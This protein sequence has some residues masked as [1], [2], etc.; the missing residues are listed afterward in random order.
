MYWWSC[1]LKDTKN[2]TMIVKIGSA[3][4]S[5]MVAPGEW[6]ICS[7]SCVKSEMACVL[8][9]D[10]GSSSVLDG[11]AQEEDTSERDRS[12][13][14]VETSISASQSPEDQSVCC[15]VSADFEE[16]TVIKNTFLQ[17]FRREPG[18]PRACSLPWCWRP[19]CINE[20]FVE[21]PVHFREEQEEVMSSLVE[22]PYFVLRDSIQSRA[23]EQFAE[24][25]EVLEEPFLVVFFT[26]QGSTARQ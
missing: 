21:V 23:V 10:C 19:E 18:R 8:C 15:N 6:E 26:G 16:E 14:G 24:I 25:P 1:S 17:V 4:Q 7:G 20:I 13:A 2:D 3:F 5:L 22:E 11:L 9:G 12:D